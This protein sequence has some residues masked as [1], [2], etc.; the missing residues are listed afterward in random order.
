M[1][2]TKSVI[3]GEFDRSGQYDSGLKSLVK[4]LQW[5]FAFLLVVIIGLL[6]NYGGMRFFGFILSESTNLS[7][8]MVLNA[9]PIALT[10]VILAVIFGFRVAL[11]AGFFVSSVAAMMV[12]PERAF[13]LAIKGMM[14][15]YSY[16]PLDTRYG[17]FWAR[18][19][20]GRGE[21]GRNT[22]KEGGGYI[23]PKVLMCPLL[24]EER[25]LVQHLRDV[26]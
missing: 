13:D 25:R 23:S 2:E 22:V 14:I 7:Q 20:W 1:E 16:D 9:L 3:K 17:Y 4:S 10:S 21:D 11:C 19:S 6:A 18:L 8:E 24:A 26:Q 12:V 5:A 15:C